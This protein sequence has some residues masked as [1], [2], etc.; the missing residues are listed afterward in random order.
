M[1]KKQRLSNAKVPEESYSGKTEFGKAW[2]GETAFKA[3]NAGRGNDIF[4]DM[5]RV[6]H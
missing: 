5:I 2:Q 4:G 3:T 6:A 1:L